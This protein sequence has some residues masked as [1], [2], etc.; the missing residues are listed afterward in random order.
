MSIIALWKALFLRRLVRR[1]CSGGS[2][3]EKLDRARRRP[4]RRGGRAEIGFE[5]GR[6]L[7]LNH[8]TA[9]LWRNECANRKNGKQ[10]GNGQNSIAALAGRF[11]VRGPH[12]NGSRARRGAGVK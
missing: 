5:K 6:L 2:G 12:Q 10:S 1:A 8:L 4:G 9:N 3:I 7:A 11:R